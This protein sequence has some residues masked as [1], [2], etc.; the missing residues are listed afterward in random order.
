M[1]TGL[2]GEVIK[3]GPAVGEH[4]NPFLVDDVTGPNKGTTLCYR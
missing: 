2:A 1:G 4:A 3:S